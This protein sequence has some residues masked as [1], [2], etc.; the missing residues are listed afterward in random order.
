MSVRDAGGREGLGEGVCSGSCSALGLA[1]VTNKR[2]FTQ[3]TV[4]CVY[5][6]CSLPPIDFPVTSASGEVA[7]RSEEDSRVIM[8]A[9]GWQ[10]EEDKL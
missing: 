4:I 7:W 5:M 2:D 6:R 8:A 9:L 3:L 10:E 1:E